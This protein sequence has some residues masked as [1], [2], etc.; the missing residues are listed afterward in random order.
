MR[1]NEMKET[2]ACQYQLSP[3]N[4]GLTFLDNDFASGQRLRAELMYPTH[5]CAPLHTE[6]QLTRTGT[7]E[8]TL[9]T[10]SPMI[11]LNQAATMLPAA[12]CSSPHISC[13]AKCRRQLLPFN[14]TS[15]AAE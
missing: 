1:A 11:D 3:A 10:E 8:S 15:V 2:Q 5:P 4:E 12:D 9:F 6:I 13:N 7:A 14:E